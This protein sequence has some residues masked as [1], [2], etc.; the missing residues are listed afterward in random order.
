MKIRLLSLPIP[1]SVAVCGGKK[2]EQVL[3]TKVYELL[4][5]SLDTS[6]SDRVQYLLISV[7]VFRP[8]S[9]TF[10]QYAFLSLTQGLT[11]CALFIARKTRSVV[12][13][14]QCPKWS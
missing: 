8:W 1:L 3:H 14:S 7:V 6:Q 10:E 2:V 12:G 4:I 5:P 13:K 11:L 9:C